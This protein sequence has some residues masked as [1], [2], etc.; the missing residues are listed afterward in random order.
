MPK[1]KTSLRLRGYINEFGE[2]VFST[3]KKMLF[4]KVCSVKVA[5]K[6]KFMISQHLLRHK[7]VKGLEL[8]KTKNINDKTGVFYQYVN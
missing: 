5:S 2:D 6:K 3:D 4:C 8:K 1:V 7:H